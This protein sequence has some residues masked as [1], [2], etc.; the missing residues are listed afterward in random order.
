MLAGRDIVGKEGLRTV[1]TKTFKD[2]KD[3]VYKDWKDK[4]ICGLFFLLAPVFLLPSLG[5]QELALEGGCTVTAL[6]SRVVVA[7]RMH[8]TDL[9]LS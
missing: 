9:V 8:C 7:T 6:T 4:D 1:R 5:L 2:W 3:E